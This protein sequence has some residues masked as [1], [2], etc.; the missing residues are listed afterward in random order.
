MVNY[1]SCDYYDLGGYCNLPKIPYAIFTKISHDPS[2]VRTR[3]NVTVTC[4]AG[5]FIES[6]NSQTTTL[7]CQ[8]D[9]QLNAT[10]SCVSV[11]KCADSLTCPWKPVD[12]ILT[13]GNR[14]TCLNITST[15][16]MKMD[17]MRTFIVTIIGKDINCSPL[18]GPLSVFTYNGLF[19]RNITMCAV[20]E[21]RMYEV[22]CKYYC[23]NG[24]DLFIK[25]ET[26]AK[27]PYVTLCEV[28]N[29]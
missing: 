2:T 8:L 10:A 7:H 20:F 6:S 23:Y 25:I 15:T 26:Y 12:D 24:Y 5:F 19:T 4:E 21:Y 16:T 3:E 29:E 22:M 18:E 9:G 14:E 28:V 27:Q 17:A 11:V 13:D 1:S